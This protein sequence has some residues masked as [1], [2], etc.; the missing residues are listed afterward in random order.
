MEVSVYVEGVGEF[1]AEKC[2]VSVYAKGI[3]KSFAEE[4]VLV[5]SV[6]ELR[7]ESEE[8]E[9]LEGRVSDC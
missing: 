2:V 4:C 7:W 1:L 6:S 8:G 5:D 9:R 3:D